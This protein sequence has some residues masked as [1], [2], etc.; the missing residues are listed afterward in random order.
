MA[1]LSELLKFNAGDPHLDIVRGNI[2]QALQQKRWELIAKQADVAGLGIP[3]DGE[4]AGDTQREAQ[5]LEMLS[6]R[7]YELQTI[8]ASYNDLEARLS[9]LPPEKKAPK[10]L[11]PSGGD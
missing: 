4:S 1:T 5:R 2:K 6:A 7:Q 3:V 9:A 10:A 8:L 11:P